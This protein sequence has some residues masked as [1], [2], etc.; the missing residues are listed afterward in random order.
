MSNHTTAATQGSHYEWEQPSPA[1]KRHCS[2]LALSA[3]CEDGAEVH[4]FLSDT[5]Y[6]VVVSLLVRAPNGDA[7]DTDRTED[8]PDIE[9]Y[10][11]R[12]EWPEEIYAGKRG[13]KERHPDPA[14]VAAIDAYKAELEEL[15]RENERLDAEI[16]GED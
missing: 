10:V 11:P 3:Y 4:L 14:V 13:P 12:S 1:D 5:D 9:E 8:W 16:L 2:D 7:Y 15:R 6:E